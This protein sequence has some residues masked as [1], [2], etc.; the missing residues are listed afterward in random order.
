M[1]LSA[2]Q[3]LLLEKSTATYE[4][5]VDRAAPYLVARGFT[6]AVARSFRFGGV[7][8]EPLPGDETFRL[9]LSIPYL[10][11]AGVVSLRFRCIDSHNCDEMGHPKYLGYPGSSTHLF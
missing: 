8:D 6:E 7:P 9:R 2:E 5:N 3:R 1:K 10:T 11:P 4:Q